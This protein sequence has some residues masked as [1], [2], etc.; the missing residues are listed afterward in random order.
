MDNEHITYTDTNLIQLK[1]CIEQYH[2]EPR[3]II[4]LLTSNM[5]MYNFIES[6]RVDTDIYDAYRTIIAPHTSLENKYISFTIDTGTIPIL[7][8][9]NYIDIKCTNVPKIVNL[10]SIA[11]VFHKQAFTSIAGECNRFLYFILSSCFVE[12][13]SASNVNHSYYQ[14]PRFGLIWTKQ[15]AMYSKRKY[16]QNACCQIQFKP[17][18]PN[19][20]TMFRLNNIMKHS[21]KHDS[22]NTFINDYKI[23]N[24]DTAFQLYNAF[25]LYDH[26]YKEKPLI[27]KNFLHMFKSNVSL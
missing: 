3:T 8:Q 15:S 23:S 22:F 25:N 11:D 16:I 4:D 7:I 18:I 2:C 1:N 14:R 12:V 9:E 10:M 6:K 13:Y 5:Y 19:N 21:I 24:S 27:R 26:V 17:Y 20:T